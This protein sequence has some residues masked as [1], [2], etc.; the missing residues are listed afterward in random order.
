LIKPGAGF[1]RY[2]ADIRVSNTPRKIAILGATS[3]IAKDLIRSFDLHADHQLTLFGRNTDTIK[4]WQENQLFAHPQFVMPYDQFN[5]NQNFDA[6][7]NFVGIGDP[8]K[9]KVMGDSILTLTKYYDDLAI[10]YLKYYPSCQYIFLSSGA[11]FGSNY[12]KPVDQNTVP[13]EPNE[14]LNSEDWYGLAKLQA[15]N[16]HRALNYYNIVDIR[17]FNYFSRTQYMSERFLITDIVRAI[18]ERAVLSTNAYNLVRDFLHPDDFY[19]MVIKVLDNKNIN[20]V[21]D[22]YTQ[23]PIDKF[24]LLNAMSEKFNLRYEMAQIDA[25]VLATGLKNNYYSKNHVAKKIGYEP[26]YSS[27]NGVTTEVAAYLK[28]LSLQA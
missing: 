18:R 4:Q 1:Q 19:Q 2:K 12:D 11:V 27:L 14:R 6:I 22:C 3:Q 24:S 8:A 13:V 17:V 21:F 16:R 10:K 20:T 7:I 26:Q 5:Q 9:A 23:A 25:G 28:A 15:E